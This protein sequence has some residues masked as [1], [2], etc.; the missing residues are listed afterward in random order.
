MQHYSQLTSEQRYQIS[1]LLKAGHTQSEI[2]ELV[3]VH[4]STISREICRNTGG[5]GY[6]PKQ[7]HAKALQRRE[8]KIRFGILE[9][10][11]LSVTTVSDG[12]L[13]ALFDGHP[14]KCCVLK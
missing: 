6:R 11:W 8:E 2:A 13:F 12:L 1:V 9:S 14:S 5:R 4:K 7:A 3:G 10:T